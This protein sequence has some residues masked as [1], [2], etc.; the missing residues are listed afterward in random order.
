MDGMYVMVPDGEYDRLCAL[1]ELC[2]RAEEGVLEGMDYEELECAAL[3]LFNRVERLENAL[4]HIQLDA[5]M[6]QANARNAL[7]GG[8]GWTSA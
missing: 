8:K 4:D 1:E 5:G 2:E 6:I 3:Y 7:K